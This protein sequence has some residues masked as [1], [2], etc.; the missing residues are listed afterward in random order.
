ML[1]RVVVK[2]TM[3]YGAE[4]WPV[5]NSHAQ[6]M[7]VVRS[8]FSG[9]QDVESEAEMVWACE[10]VMHGWQRCERLSMD[11][12]KGSRGSPKKYWHCWG[13]EM[14]VDW[15]VWVPQSKGTFSVSSCYKFLLTSNTLDQNYSFWP[16][17]QIWKSRAPYK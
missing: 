6:K 1:Y 12:S 2:P 3:L 7:K 9:G 15:L 16:W 14:V 5:Q 13:E 11:G 17:R 8:G 4:C 10:E